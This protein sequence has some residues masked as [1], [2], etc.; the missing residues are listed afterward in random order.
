MS[1]A[2][3]GRSTTGSS[4]R[5]RTSNALAVTASGRRRS[6]S[7]SIGST[8]TPGHSWTRSATDSFA[9]RRWAVAAVS[10][11]ATRTAQRGDM[12]SPAAPAPARPGAS[13]ALGSSLRSC[14]DDR[15][16]G[17]AVR[18]FPRAPRSSLR[19][20]ATS[21]G[22]RG[23]DRRAA[24]RRSGTWGSTRE[25]CRRRRR[26]APRRRTRGMTGRDD[27]VRASRGAWHP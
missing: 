15:V 13:P 9:L 20:C 23:G 18:Q 16:V 17:Y 1:C 3:T 10:G 27:H 5:C 22:E 14:I 6:R 12:P 11:A 21:G 26:C 7:P 2:N 8:T 4:R 19:S 25:S 24:C